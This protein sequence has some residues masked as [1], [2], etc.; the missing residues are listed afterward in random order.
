MSKRF[1]VKPEQVRQN[2]ASGEDRGSTFLTLP[3][4]ITEW[5]PEKS[6]KYNLD[7][8][9]YEVSIDNH[10]DGIPKGSIWYKYPFSVHRNVGPEEKMI[11]CPTS[12]GQRCPICEEVRRLSKNYEANEAVIKTLR[13]QK[14]VAFNVLNPGDETKVCVFAWSR[15]KFAAALEKELANADTELL[16]FFDVVDGQTLKVRFTDADF[17]GNKYLECDRID[18][19]PRDDMDEDEV[20]AATANLDTIFSVLPYEQVKAMFEGGEAPTATI[21]KAADP[22]PEKEAPKKKGFRT[23][24]T[25]A[26]AKEEKPKRRA[27]EPDPEPDPDDDFAQFDG[28]DD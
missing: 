4:N 14:F 21:A 2:A 25:P 27:P 22:E 10:P 13:P 24:S 26:T 18:F 3:P 17:M 5:K 23:V 15:G 6:G 12:I 19:T 28:E 20:L 7:I 11:I 1:R 16:S 9:P 8:L